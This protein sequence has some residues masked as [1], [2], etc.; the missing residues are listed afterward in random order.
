MLSDGFPELT[1]DA[2]E[3]LGYQAVHDLFGRFA[4]S[5]PQELIARLAA[6]AEDWTAGSSPSDD[7]TVVALRM[8]S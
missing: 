4:A 8:T 6:A 7:I 2:G 3:P 5:P 1:N